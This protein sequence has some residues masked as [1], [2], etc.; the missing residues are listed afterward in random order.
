MTST[1][2]NSGIFDVTTSYIGTV[3]YAIVARGTPSRL[4]T[5]DTIYNKT[6]ISGVSYGTSKVSLENSGV[7]IKSKFTATG[8]SA[9][10]AYK[11][12]VYLNSTIGNSKVMIKNFRTKRVSNAAA[13]KIAMS[14]VIN[15]T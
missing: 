7:N 13:I 3:Y 4:I 5:H 10:T 14:D 6:L 11:I 12:A 15:E 1:L 2:S 8:L 9:Q